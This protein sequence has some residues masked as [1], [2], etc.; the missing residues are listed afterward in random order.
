MFCTGDSN[1]VD[2]GVFFDDSSSGILQDFL[3]VS[4][5]GNFRFFWQGLIL[6]FIGAMILGFIRS[7][8]LG[9]FPGFFLGH[10]FEK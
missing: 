10:F 6:G 4:I 8:C 1:I 5:L 7:F 2:A 9:L 3:V